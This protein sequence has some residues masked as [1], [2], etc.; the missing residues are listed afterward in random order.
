MS[1]L[2]VVRHPIYQKHDPGYGHPESPARLVAI[3]RLL[4]GPA[5]RMVE[6]VKPRLAE[7]DEICTV[8]SEKYYR[9]LE[10]SAGKTIRLDG[11]TGA[12]PHSFEAALMAAGGVI[13]L[14]EACD[15]GGIEVGFAFVRPPGHHAE[16]NRAMG[17]CLFNNV[18]VA[19]EYARRKLGY[20][21]ILIV[22]W[23]LHHGNGT[24]HAFYDDPNVLYFSTHQYPFFPG[25][26]DLDET[27]QGAGEGY[28]VNV[29]LYPGH[30]D[31]EFAQIM[32]RL[33]CPITG[34]FK[35]ELILVSAGFD[36]HFADPL[37]SQKVSPIGFAAIGRALDELADDHCRGK[38]V[39]VLEGGYN[40]GGQ[41]DSIQA[42]IRQLSGA[43]ALLSSELRDEP[44][45]P[46]IPAL[47]RAKK[48]Q[49]RY[50]PN[51]EVY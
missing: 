42:M 16:A 6:F 47:V 51:M 12:S 5:R 10:E 11:D 50:W 44:H 35:P 33:L 27:G 25:T 21:R 45:R 23:D 7:K 29:P 18:A 14:V 39:F 2:G 1:R 31:T 3:D 43:G 9:M 41:A 20:K 34:E 4:D 26:G 49:Q 8:H 19:A 30:G 46:D 38:L 24:Q 37:G 15:Q 40:I 32:V 22:D 36:I 28:T 13:E 17:F 48:V